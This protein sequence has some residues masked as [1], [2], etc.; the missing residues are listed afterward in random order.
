MSSRKGGGGRRGPRLNFHDEVLLEQEAHQ[1][2]REETSRGLPH[3]YLCVA[4]N[5]LYC[6]VF[7]RQTTYAGGEVNLQSLSLCGENQYQ[8]SSQAF[9]SLDTTG[10]YSS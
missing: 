6:I 1:Q 9:L 4:Q 3:D 10:L 7:S 2:R 5:S 8:Y